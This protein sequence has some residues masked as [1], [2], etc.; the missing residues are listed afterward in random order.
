LHGDPGLEAGLALLDPRIRESASGRVLV[1][2][3]A[4]NTGEPQR[5]FL[6]IDWFDRQGRPAGAA[7]RAW[8]P[9]SIDARASQE[10][11]IQV[12]VP[13]AETWRW[14]ATTHPRVR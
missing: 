3:L 11:V 7:R 14:H 9:I 1:F 10:V 5:L 2:Q 8:V 6:A 13:E 12:P 4:N